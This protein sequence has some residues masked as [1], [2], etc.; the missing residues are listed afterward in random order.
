MCFMYKQLN[1]VHISNVWSPG[2]HLKQSKYM[3]QQQ[4]LVF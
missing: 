1:T 4:V 3:L 2:Q